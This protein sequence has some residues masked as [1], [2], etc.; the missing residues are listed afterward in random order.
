MKYFVHRLAD[1][2]SQNIG[3]GTRIWQ[4]VV[5][6]KDARIGENCNIS[7]HCFIE[8]D[9]VMGDNVT[10]KCGNYL[11]DGLRIEDDV[12]I[13]PNAS[14]TND[15]FPRSKV[16][17]DKFLTT[18]LRKGCSIGAGA[19]ILPGVTIGQNSMIGAGAIVTADVLP[20]VV[21]AGSPARVFKRRRQ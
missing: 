2:Q 13:G 11:W 8:N 16:Y 9:V 20:N 1:C 21:V 18:I 5:V 10:V 4:F 15:K 19:V 6:L 12:F 7:A 3:E 17:P 14:F